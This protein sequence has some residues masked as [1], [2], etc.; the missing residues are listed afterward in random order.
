MILSQVECKDRSHNFHC[1]RVDP[2]PGHFYLFPLRDFYLFWNIHKEK[3]YVGKQNIK[4]TYSE[5]VEGL[6]HNEIE[7]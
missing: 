6:H 4:F 7:K 1:L 3:C 2:L 5:S